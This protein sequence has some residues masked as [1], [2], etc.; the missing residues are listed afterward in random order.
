MKREKT[1][2]IVL[3]TW[4]SRERDKLVVF[5]TPERGK[6][7]AWAY[8]A[9]S[10]K[11]RFGAALEPLARV[12]IET[13]AKDTDDTVRLESAELVRSMFAAQQDLATNLALTW[14]AELADT[15][16]QS[17][18]PS[19]LLFRLIDRLSIALLDRVPV[20]PVVAY[21]E[22]WILKLAGIFPGT[23]NCVECQSPLDLPL[24]YGPS[25]GGF[26][27][28]NC[29]AGAGE[30][31]PNGA[32]RLLMA[33]STKP[34]ESI[35]DSNPSRED[36]FEVRSLAATLRRDFLGHELKTWEVLQGVLRG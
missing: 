4:P 19:E 32:S 20:E 7:K 13:I 10:I 23:R 36:L 27:C 18:E 5:L 22:V 31:L 25:H 1:D 33:I 3:Q 29:E 16:A 34:V 15:F 8:G 21:A 9:R 24:R 28:G 14:L 6:L 2:A 11:S 17:D 26:V 12:R 30:R 35:A